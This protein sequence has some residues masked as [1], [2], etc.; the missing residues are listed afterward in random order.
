MSSRPCPRKEQGRVGEAWDSPRVWQMS[1]AQPASSGPRPAGHALHRGQR[2]LS[3]KETKLARRM[4]SRPVV[5][6]GKSR[7]R[8]QEA[9]EILSRA[10]LQCGGVGHYHRPSSL[11]RRDSVPG[12]PTALTLDGQPGPRAD[13]ALFLSPTGL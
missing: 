10:S 3:E 8:L 1:R 11:S 13:N 7:A 6:G 2:T 5:C 9:A 12:N 4:S